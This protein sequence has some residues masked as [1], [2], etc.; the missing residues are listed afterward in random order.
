MYSDVVLYSGVSVRALEKRWSEFNI[1]VFE[2]TES[3]S[4]YTTILDEQLCFVVREVFEI[5]PDACDIYI[6]GACR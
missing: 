5:L 2:R 6:I 1:T 3:R 4:T